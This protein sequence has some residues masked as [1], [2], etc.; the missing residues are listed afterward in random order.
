MRPLA[1]VALRA[2]TARR[3]LRKLLVCAVAA[4]EAF[5]LQRKVTACAAPQGSLVSSG[6]LPTKDLYLIRQRAIVTR[7]LLLAVVLTAPAFAATSAQDYA[8]RLRRAESAT[9]QLIERDPPATAE[10]IVSAMRAIKQS[11]PAREEVELDGQPVRVNNAWLHEALDLVIKNVNGDDEQLRSML[12]EI[13]DRLYQLEQRVSAVQKQSAAPQAD[14]HTRIQR[15]LARSEYVPAEKKDSAI[16]RWLT[17]ARDK[18]VELL[19]RLFG[20]RRAPS[21][22]FN[23]GTVSVFRV[24]IAIILLAAASFGLGKMMRRWRL[25]RQK[26][27]DEDVREVLGEE[28]AGDVTAG[29]LLTR[30]NELARQGDFR[31]AIRRAYI[32]LLC[33]LEQRGKVRLHRAKTNRDYLDELKPERS[34]YPTFSVMTGAFEHVWYGHELATE[35]EFNDFITLYQ[36]TVS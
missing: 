11:L 12:V 15:I 22:G 10:E 31:G 17:K 27:N 4:G 30:A 28:L 36:E 6:G 1:K 14:D 34:L 8:E 33:D 35:S 9:D 21:G 18:I 29:D 3:G 25:R 5:S 24:I 23:A 16:Q 7:L 19:M 26:E 32:A 20:G 2:E 13:A